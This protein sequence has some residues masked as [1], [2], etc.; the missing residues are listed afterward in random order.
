MQCGITTNAWTSFMLSWATDVFAQG[1]VLITS[2][3]TA[4]LADFGFA[5]SEEGSGAGQHQ[6]VLM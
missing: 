6:P 1:N 4:V 5:Q 3:G 2:S